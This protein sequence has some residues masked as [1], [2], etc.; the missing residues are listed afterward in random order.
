MKK[1]LDNFRTEFNRLKTEHEENESKYTVCNLIFYMNHQL[2]SLTLTYFIDFMFWQVD[3]VEPKWSLE[4]EPALKKINPSS[5][6]DEEKRF[7]FCDSPK[8]LEKIT[9]YRLHSISD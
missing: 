1:K 5:A 2:I 6:V 3:T 8:G 4:N 7:F 9:F